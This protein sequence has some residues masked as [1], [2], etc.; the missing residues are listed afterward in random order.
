MAAGIWPL[1]RGASSRFLDRRIFL[2]GFRTTV[3]L[4]CSLRTDLLRSF[5]V[6]RIRTAVM[7]RRTSKCRHNRADAS[8]KQSPCRN[9]R[10]RGSASRS[11]SNSASG[12]N[13]HDDLVRG[14]HGS[15]LDVLSNCS[16]AAVVAPNADDSVGQPSSRIRRWPRSVRH[17]RPDGNRGRDPPAKRMAAIERLRKAW[18]WLALTGGATLLNPWGPLIY[19]ALIRQERVMALHNV[20][21]VEW[22]GI[23]VA[24][25][26]LHQALDWRDPQSSFWWLVV[27]AVASLCIAIWQKRLGA[28]IL[29]AGACYFGFRHVRL[30]ALFACVVVIA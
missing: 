28:G 6:G 29:L 10:A 8:Q 15:P 23:P 26:S 7:A 20:W 12:G 16:R 17:L 21:V 24:W 25:S 2:H 4:S 22:E 30:Q 5:S 9:P 27:A 18:P 3:G 13:G 14:V 11:K 1:G 19:S